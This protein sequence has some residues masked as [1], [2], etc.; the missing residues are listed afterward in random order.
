MILMVISSPFEKTQD[1]RDSDDDIL[2]AEELKRFCEEQKA[3]EQRL[4]PGVCVVCDHLIFFR[5]A[6]TFSVH[7]IIALSRDKFSGTD[8]SLISQ[9]WS[10]A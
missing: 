5:V 8:H 2:K 6:S 7:A 3:G 10:R 4:R 9:N 1:D